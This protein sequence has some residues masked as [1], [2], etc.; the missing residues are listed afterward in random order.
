MAKIEKMAKP[1]S[2]ESD[3]IATLIEAA[4]N[5]NALYGAFMLHF[6][7][8]ELALYKVLVRL[9]GVTDAVGRAIFSG[10]RARD[11]MTYAESIALNT[12]ISEEHIKELACVFSQLTAINTM[13]DRIVHHGLPAY[14]K[15]GI[16]FTD[17]ARKN[18]YGKAVAYRVTVDMLVSMS[19]DLSTIE[20]HLWRFARGFTKPPGTDCSLGPS[21]W[22]YKFPQPIR[23]ADK[24]G[25]APPKRRDPPPSSPQ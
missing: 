16:Y 20:F 14:K 17:E 3:H 12:K 22:R 10:T 18:R 8:V 6:T 1:P 21:T 25:A 5:L 9:A 24:S 2:S 15:D 19:H 11:M 4:D 7:R 23:L 13:R